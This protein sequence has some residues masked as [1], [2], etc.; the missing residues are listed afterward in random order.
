MDAVSLGGFFFVFVCCISFF[1][2]KGNV[3][4]CQR[5]FLCV[6]GLQWLTCPLLGPPLP[7]VGFATLRT[8]CLFFSKSLH[9][10]KFQESV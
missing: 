9:F 10:P 3:G 8:V 2:E 4:F 6:R 1:L 5:L 7:Q